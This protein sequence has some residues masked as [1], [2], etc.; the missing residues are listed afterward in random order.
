M[1]CGGDQIVMS[2]KVELARVTTRGAV[3]LLVGKIL[4]R[5]V[6]VLGGFCANSPFG[7]SEI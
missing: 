3:H 1:D 2:E 6:G 4:S 7:A 5:G